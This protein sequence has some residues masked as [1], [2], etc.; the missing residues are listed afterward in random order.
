MTDFKIPDEAVY[1]AH[2]AWRL[3]LV[4]QESNRVA[5]RAALDAALP[6]MFE[7]CGWWY[8]TPHG[9]VVTKTMISSDSNPLY[10]LKEPK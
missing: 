3:G 8:E 1:A 7:Q 2:A 5:L 9:R 6:L 4:A 10:R